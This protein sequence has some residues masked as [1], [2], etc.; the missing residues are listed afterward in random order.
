MAPSNDKSCRV[1]CQTLTQ[2]GR[3]MRICVHKWTT[4]ALDNGLSH[5]RLQAL[6]RTNAR[7]V[8]IGHLGTIFIDILIEMHTFSLDKMHFKMS[9]AKFG[10]FASASMCWTYICIAM[11]Y[12]S[13][14][15]PN[16]SDPDLNVSLVCML[17]SQ[18][19][20]HIYNCATILTVITTTGTIKSEFLKTT[21]CFVYSEAKI[22]HLLAWF[23]CFRDW[24]HWLL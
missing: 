16:R 12:W 18:A 14:D 4:T 8:F 6:T 11:I 15:D 19:A 20:G 21:I 23:I 2:W 24:R 3:A 13:V 9:A 5:S 7:I 1:E 17:L 10:H 22:N